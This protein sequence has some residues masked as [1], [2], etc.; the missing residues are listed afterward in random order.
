[1]WASRTVEASQE[2]EERP[3]W[4]SRVRTWCCSAAPPAS[5]SRRRAPLRSAVPTSP[6]RGQAVDLGDP[7]GVQ[8]LFDDLG[9]LDHLV[10]TAGEPLALMPVAEL[11]VA[12]A[13]AFFGLR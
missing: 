13:R 5:A 6:S 12:R 11:D 3:G 2:R 10:Y 7:A 1:M 9:E 8:V 4:I